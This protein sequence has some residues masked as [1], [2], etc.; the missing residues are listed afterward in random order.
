MRTNCIGCESL[1]VNILASFV[2]EKEPYGYCWIRSFYIWQP[3]RNCTAFDETEDKDV[4]TSRRAARRH[5]LK[6]GDMDGHTCLLS[7]CAIHYP[8]VRRSMPKLEERSDG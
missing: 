7:V 1:K 5:H 4:Y 6:H 3:E 8:K 2:N